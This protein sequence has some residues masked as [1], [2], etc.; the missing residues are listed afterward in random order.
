MDNT[1]ILGVMMLVVGLLFTATVFIWH[2]GHRNVTDT[3]MRNM[4][5]HNNTWVTINYPPNQALQL[6]KC[7]KRLPDGMTPAD[8]L[9]RLP[10]DKNGKIVL[11]GDTVVCGDLPPLVVDKIRKMGHSDK[12]GK[13]DTE[14]VLTDRE[15]HDVF[16]LDAELAVE[17]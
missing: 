1:S 7:M 17:C 11:W 13:S 6:E 14:F 15:G 4:P 10:V 9:L 12:H 5:D 8:V 16:N 3:I 2:S